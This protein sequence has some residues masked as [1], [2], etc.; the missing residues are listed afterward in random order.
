M[1]QPMKATLHLGYATDC[2]NARQ[3]NEEPCVIVLAEQML[4]SSIR[5]ERQGSL[6]ALDTTNK[7]L[8]T[9]KTHCKHRALRNERPTPHFVPSHIQT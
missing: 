2:A 4:I 8:K 3:A 9:T 1:K 5:D 6:R 7:Q